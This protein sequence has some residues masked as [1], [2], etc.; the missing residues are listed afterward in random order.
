MIL[1]TGATG[2][3]GK[4]LVR[5]MDAKK[6]VLMVRNR[7]ES[8]FRQR[9]ASLDDENSLYEAT[10]GIEVVIHL[11]AAVGIVDPAANYRINFEGTR[12]LVGACKKNKVK[13]II[14]LSSVSAVQ[15]KR[16]AYGQSKL[17]AEKII[18]DSGIDYVI[19]RP[20]L[21]FGESRQFKVIKDIIAKYPVIPII[22]SGK[23]IMQPISVDDLVEMIIMSLGMKN[24]I[25]NL[26][27]PSRITF[28]QMISKI[29]SS[30]GIKKPML[31]L[32]KS[33][34]LIAA[35]FLEKALRSPPITRNQVYALTQDST[36][37][38]SDML[39]KF[40]LK[41]KTFDDMVK[42]FTKCC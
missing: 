20:T 31:H 24:E 19:L 35:F 27:G 29:A 16:E 41:P 11:A 3:I 7:I 8:R 22:G 10:K 13:K 25:I 40:K 42:N 6:A 33:L 36:T 5:R 17:Q 4:R 9:I 39:A 15:K 34:C 2:F 32:P 37:D 14:F 28:N 12:K 18:I 23:S 1:V 38:I 30:M 21:V 26:A